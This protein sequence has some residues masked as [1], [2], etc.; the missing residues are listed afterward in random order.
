M[1]AGRSDLVD[2]DDVTF[3][4]E[5]PGEFGAYLVKTTKDREVWIPKSQCE[6]NDDG[7]FTMPRWIAEEKGLV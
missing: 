7:S 4:H 3:M 5:T 2:V 1:S 6:R